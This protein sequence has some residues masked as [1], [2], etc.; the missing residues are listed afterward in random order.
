MLFNLQFDAG[1]PYLIFNSEDINQ[2]SRFICSL[3][4]KKIPKEQRPYFW[5]LLDALDYMREEVRKHGS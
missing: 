5:H 1:A 2:F 3:D 4:Y